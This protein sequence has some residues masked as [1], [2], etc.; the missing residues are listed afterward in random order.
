MLRVLQASLLA[1]SLVTLA[2]CEDPAP[3]ASGVD[4]TSGTPGTEVTITGA[5]FAAGTTASI[6]GKDLQD[7]VRV[8]EQTIRGTVAS[9]S[10]VGTADVTVKGRDGQ[11]SRLSRAFTVE[12]AGPPPHPCLGDEKRITSIPPDGSVVKI[13]LHH[14]DGKVDRKNFPTTDISAIELRTIAM[15]DAPS[16]EKADADAKDVDAEEADK[17]PSAP[18]CSAIYLVLDDNK[19]RELFDADKT[20]DL[21]TQAQKIA[22]GLGKRLVVAEGLPE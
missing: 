6:A 7:A 2:A 11:E 10:P 21:K 15:P 5:H 20:V 8:D 17:A 4:P 19:G 18:V 16:A 14:E 12:A 13:D 9:D 3:S 1:A 22:Q